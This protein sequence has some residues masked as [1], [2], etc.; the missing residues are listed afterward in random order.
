MLVCLH[1]Q[2]FGQIIVALAAPRH[3]DEV[4]ISQE[5]QE[6]FV[7]GLKAHANERLASYQKPRKYV[8]VEK[9]PRNA[10]GKVNKKD[11]T[12]RYFPQDRTAGAGLS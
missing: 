11:L 8:V 3:P 4:I 9:L 2:T 10:M 12:A 6:R 1:P 7:S 5:A